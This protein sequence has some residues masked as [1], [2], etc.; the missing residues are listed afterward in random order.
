M[1]VT[2]VNNKQCCGCGA[3]EDICQKQCVNLKYNEEG[4]LCSSVDRTVC[5]ECGLCEKV[6]PVLKSIDKNDK[7]KIK[8][9]YVGYAIDEKMRQSGSSGGVFSVLAQSIIDAGGIVYGAAFDESFSVKHVRVDSMYALNKILTS[10][11]VQSDIRGVYSKIETD[12]RS[13]K[14]VLFC[15]TPCQVAAIHHF[16]E[17]K[18]LDANLILVDF[19]CHG[20]PSPRVWDTYK[21]FLEEKLGGTLKSVNFRDKRRGWHDYFFVATT[22]SG[23]SVSES[24]DLNA[25]MQ[26]FISD[27]NLRESCFSCAC[28]PNNYFSDITLGDAWK[29]ER[30]KPEWTDDKGT[31]F[32]VAR[33][34]KG[35][36]Q[37]EKLREN[38]DLAETSYEQWCAWNPSLY[39]C[40]KKH[41]KRELFFEKIING[42]STLFWH[43][44]SKNSL[45]KLIRYKCKQAVRNLGLENFLRRKI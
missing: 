13:G 43:S 16:I 36:S 27:K 33:T 38:L 28:K 19:I 42:E 14:K 41:E 32:F 39:I 9:A 21:F 15:G 1:S 31:S 25:Y 3:C 23:K 37:L 8:K 7:L 44:E 35:D 10:K 6:C 2:V 34:Q 5:I 45:K 4:F 12:L 22:N 40:A 11:Y 18:K 20:V 17:Q 24:H 30:E 26:T 29:I